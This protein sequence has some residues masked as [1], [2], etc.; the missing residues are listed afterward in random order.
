M[1]QR[2]SVWSLIFNDMEL[3]PDSFEVS[4]I[5]LRLR[6][7]PP[8]R[9]FLRD[10]SEGAVYIVETLHILEIIPV[11]ICNKVIHGCAVLENGEPDQVILLVHMF[12]R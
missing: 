4:S 7:D 3:P 12:L 11:H 1:V 9:W 6:L 8:K 5:R 10:L 2:V